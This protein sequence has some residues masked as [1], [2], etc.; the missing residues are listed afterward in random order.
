L[1]LLDQVQL[2]RDYGLIIK[3]YNYKGDRFTVQKIV[4]NPKG[5]QQAYLFLTS[6]HDMIKISL[7]IDAF[8]VE[9]PIMEEDV[10]DT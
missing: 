1:K 7:P 2:A 10:A 4:L 5:D 6:I 3:R 8:F 9:D